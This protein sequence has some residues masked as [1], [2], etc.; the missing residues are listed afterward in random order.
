MNCVQRD[1]EALSDYLKRFVQLKAQVLN[2]P[3][4]AVI[5]A[6]IEGLATVQCEARFAREPPTTVKELFEIMNRYA[7]S[8]DDYRRRKAS[9]NH[10]RQA[11]KVQ[12]P[13][14]TPVQRNERPLRSINNLQEDSGQ[15]APE[16]AQSSPS[17]SQPYRSFDQSS[18]GG[19]GSRGSRRGR[20]GRGRGRGH[21]PSYCFLC[22]ENAEHIT[23]VQI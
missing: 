12:S 9:R 15:S 14:Q 1:D 23:R 22:G 18:C 16:Q 6:A 7:R 5:A 19:R 21:R 20:D 13:T 3:E 10:Q 17:Q 2:V 4:A 11:V 8:D